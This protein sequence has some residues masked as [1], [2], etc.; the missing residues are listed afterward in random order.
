[1]IA[2]RLMLDMVFMVRMLDAK[3][4]DVALTGRSIEIQYMEDV[5][6]DFS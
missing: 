1:M 4:L 5:T 6:N 3:L 2:T